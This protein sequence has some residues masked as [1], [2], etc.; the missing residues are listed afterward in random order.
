MFLFNGDHSRTSARIGNTRCL[1]ST[2]YRRT[3]IR[4]PAGSKS[5]TRHSPANP[6][7][8]SPLLWRAKVGAARRAGSQGYPP[9]PKRSG[10]GGWRRCVEPALETGAEV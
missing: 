8:R 7:T 6:P 2:P 3:A 5:P 4:I 1:F 9:P 10:G